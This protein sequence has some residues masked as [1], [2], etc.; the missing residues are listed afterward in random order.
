MISRPNA[1]LALVSLCYRDRIAWWCFRRSP[2]Y[3]SAHYSAT[4]LPGRRLETSQGRY[5]HRHIG[6]FS[7]CSLQWKTNPRRR[8]L[9]LPPNAIFD[10]NYCSKMA[11]VSSFPTGLFELMLDLVLSAVYGVSLADS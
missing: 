6:P 8:W 11:K 10:L 2:I 3:N 9:N 7:Y 1:V 4:R 5:P